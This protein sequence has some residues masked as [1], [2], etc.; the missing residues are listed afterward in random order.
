MSALVTSSAG[1]IEVR[2]GSNK[3]IFSPIREF[4]TSFFDEGARRSNVR[5]STTDSIS[6]SIDTRSIDAYAQGVEITTQRRYD[7][8]VVKIWSGE[9]G[10]Q[11]RKNRFGMDNER[12]SSGTLAFA[13]SDYFNAKRFIEAQDSSSPLW[14]GIITYPIVVGD[15]D[16]TE[17]GN[18]NG[19][20]EPLSI[21]KIANF[22]SIDAPF[23]AHDVKGAFGNGNY[24][25]RG[26]TE[27]VVT[28]FEFNERERE[29]GFLDLI[30]TLGDIQLNGYFSDSL[31]RL[32]PFKDER[33]IRNT[34]GSF[35]DSADLNAAISLMTGSTDNYI[36]SSY[37]SAACGRDY[38]NTTSVGTDSLAFGGMTY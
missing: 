1:L 6:G 18:F 9:H 17:N 8:G 33:L 25:S 32:V 4:E 36:R 23:E 28:V 14:S 2:I 3:P 27:Q 34:S 29:I 7:A 38:D 13:D 37:K 31:A 15:N 19:V 24:H 5:A 20:I 26:S 35:Y 30:D 22:T 11:L 16:Q 10:H 21:R 12:L